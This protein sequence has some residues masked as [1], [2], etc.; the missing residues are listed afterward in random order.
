MTLRDSNQARRPVMPR[1]KHCILA[2]LIERRRHARHRKAAVQM[3]QPRPAE[4]RYVHRSAV[5]GSSTIST[6]RYMPDVVLAQ[7]HDSVSSSEGQSSLPLSC[8]VRSKSVRYQFERTRS[9]LC[10][11]L[12]RL[13]T[14]KIPMYSTAEARQKTRRYCVTASRSTIVESSTS[15]TIC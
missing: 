11:S 4:N 13:G 7:F 5:N 10:A 2:I 15:W 14:C 12:R 1:P 9:I 6:R 3:N 8:S